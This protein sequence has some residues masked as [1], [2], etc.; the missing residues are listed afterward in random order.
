MCGLTGY[1]GNRRPQL[2]KLKLISIL[3][4]ARGKDSVGF[5][6]NNTV[7][8]GVYEA[9]QKDYGDPLNFFGEKWFITPKKFE[10]NTV[11]I[12]NRAGTVGAKTKENSHPFEY[13]KDGVKHYF[14]HNGTLTNHHELARQHDLDFSKFQVDSKLLGHIIVEHGFSVLTEYAGYAAFLYYREDQPNRIYAWKG[15]SRE[16]E[17]A[18]E[19]ERPLF[20]A[21]HDK[22]VYFAST[23]EALCCAL[24]IPNESVHE[25]P[26]NTLMVFEDA[27][28]IEELVYDRSILPKRARATT[29]RN[30]DTSAA[31]WN[32]TRGGYNNVGASVR[33]SGVELPLPKMCSFSIAEDHPAARAGNN[34]YFFRGRY[35]CNGHLASGIF[36][37]DKTTRTAKRSSTNELV[38][39][40]TGTIYEPMFIYYGLWLADIDSMGHANQL[41]YKA[42]DV[43]AAIDFLILEKALHPNSIHFHYEGGGAGNTVNLVLVVGNSRFAGGLYER[44]PVLGY[45]SYK[46]FP[47]CGTYDVTPIAS[48][49]ASTLSIPFLEPANRTNMTNIVE[50]S[51]EGKKEEKTTIETGNTESMTGLI[52]REDDY[53]INSI[54]GENVNFMEDNIAV[55]G[56]NQID[57]MRKGLKEVEDKLEV[58]YDLYINTT[59]SLPLSNGPYREYVE[60]NRR[61]SVLHFLATYSSKGRIEEMFAEMFPGG[62]TAL[63]F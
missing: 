59:A 10:S 20:Y 45:Y 28:I 58:L 44:V 13:V 16:Y 56:L 1:C 38:S 42:A 54:Y 25:V 49:E 34:L 31:A 3:L 35:Y 7:Y 18:L 61:I 22:G 39:L 6:L 8:R 46:L 19:T 60:L 9:Y 2:S 4:R 5:L 50:G 43:N 41:I 23:Y 55:I 53:D 62:N 12:H 14:A 57:I 47:N 52:R 51:V 30:N 48:T 15:A 27:Q 40:D 11:I 36:L 32:T 26:D 17:D 24:D 21:F 37:Y 33:R 29:H 63:P